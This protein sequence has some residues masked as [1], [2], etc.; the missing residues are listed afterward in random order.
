MANETI[1][2]KT[3]HKK[4]IKFIHE[5]GAEKKRQ[6]AKALSSE[7]T[8]ICSGVFL[9]MESNIHMTTDNKA[10]RA[11]LHGSRNNVRISI[12]WS[13]KAFPTDLRQF[14]LKFHGHSFL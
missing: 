7:T 9:R 3:N 11:T 4:V 13:K 1:F 5:A 6:I 12:I 14:I 10:I 8:R 2:D